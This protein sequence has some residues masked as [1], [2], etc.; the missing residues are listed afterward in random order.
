MLPHVITYW[1]NHVQ[2]L[3]PRFLSLDLQQHKH[4]CLWLWDPTQRFQITSNNDLVAATRFY[5]YLIVDLA[6]VDSCVIRMYK[7]FQISQRI[8]YK[9]F[10][11]LK[12]IARVSLLY[13]DK[14]EW[15]PKRF[16]GLGPFL[17]LLQKIGQV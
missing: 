13:M 16:R 2:A 4:P 14:L 15:N 5:H 7:T 12:N 11:S 9:S 1:H 17:K 3:N 10:K 6:P 8:T